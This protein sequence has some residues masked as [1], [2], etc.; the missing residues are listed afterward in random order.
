MKFIFFIIKSL[1]ATDFSIETYLET[2]PIEIMTERAV[3]LKQF[4]HDHFLQQRSNEFRSNK[5][6]KVTVKGNN[7]VQTFEI[8]IISHRN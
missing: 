6:A 8:Q 5:N 7:K 1:F 4:C 3:R 2:G